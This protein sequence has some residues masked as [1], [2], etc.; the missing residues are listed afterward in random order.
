[1]KPETWI[2]IYGAIIGTSALLLNFKSWWDSGPKLSLSLIPDGMIITPGSGVDERDLIILTV[3]NRGNAPTM[4]TNMVL[5]EM[6]SW[7]QR[8]RMRP[9]ASYVITN[10]QHLGYPLN[11]PSDLEPSKRWTGIIRKREDIISDLRTGNFYTGIY[12]SH[13]DRPYLKRIPRKKEKL[14]EGT[15]ALS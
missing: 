1:M 13:R 14:P 2:A 10:P 15:K 7:W 12:T 4:V 5:F 11:I 3:L 9:K 6:T 8:W